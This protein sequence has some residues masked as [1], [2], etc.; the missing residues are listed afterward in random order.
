MVAEARAPAHLLMRRGLLSPTVMSGFSFRK[1]FSPMPLT[2]ISSSIFLK[3]PFF[4]RYSMM[5]CAAPS[6]H[7]RQRRDLRCRSGIQVDDRRGR[8]GQRRGF[9]SKNDVAGRDYEERDHRRE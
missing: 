3:P 8:C 1:L 2:F 4:S 5:R 6:H 7:Y 9:L